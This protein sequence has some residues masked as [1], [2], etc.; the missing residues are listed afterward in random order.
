VTSA[1]SMAAAGRDSE[2]S[3]ADSSRDFA[4][5]ERDRLRLDHRLERLAQ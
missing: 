4:A 5:R 1:A 2:M 3:V